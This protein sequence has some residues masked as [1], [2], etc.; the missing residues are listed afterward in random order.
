MLGLI[1]VFRFSLVLIIVSLF[2]RLRMMFS[3][4]RGLCEIKLVVKRV[5]DREE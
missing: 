3:W 5:F 1:R 2:V 4:E